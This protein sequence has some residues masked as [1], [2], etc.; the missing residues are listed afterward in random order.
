MMAFLIMNLG[1]VKVL[2][3][4]ALRVAENLLSI[5]VWMRNSLQNSICLQLP[6]VNP[7]LE[8]AH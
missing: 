6:F 3:Q 5:S 1:D 7:N 4:A 2:C 8:Q